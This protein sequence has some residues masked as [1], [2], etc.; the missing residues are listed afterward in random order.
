M[1][2]YFG[3]EGVFAERA[4]DCAWG[5]IEGPSEGF[6]GYDAAG[7]NLTEESVHALV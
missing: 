6:V 5:G 1:T 2:R 3:R 7:W 4:A